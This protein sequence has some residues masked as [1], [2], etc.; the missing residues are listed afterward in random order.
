MPALRQPFSALLGFGRNRAATVLAAS[1][2]AVAGCGSAAPKFDQ[3]TSPETVDAASFDPAGLSAPVTEEDCTLSSG[4][5]T[6]CLKIQLKGAPADHAVGP[7]CPRTVYDTA[8]H[9]GIWF[10]D[11]TVYDLDGDFV[12]GLANLYGDPVWKLYDDTTGAVRVTDTREACAAAARPDVDPAYNNYCVECSLDYVGGGVGSTLLIPKKPGPR[13]TPAGVLGLPAVGAALNGVPFEG[14]APVAAILKNHTI[15]AL[16]DCGGHVN[17]AVGYHYHAATGCSR[18]IE[19]GDGHAALIGYAIDG[20]AM[21]AMSEGDGTTPTDLDDC[22]GHRDATRGYHYHVAG[23]GENLFIGCLH[24]ETAVRGAGGVEPVPGG[25]DP[26]P[27]VAGQTSSCCGDGTC[28]GPETAAN[29]T[30]DCR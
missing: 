25:D 19:K 14:P 12:K 24:G 17:L 15:A 4:H 9:A 22:R 20:Y 2:L 10:K 11:G 21:H 3:A 8:D 7:F 18:K 30:A 23:A 28:D 5:V 27:C 1:A 13:S 26:T 29:C 6:T 16:D